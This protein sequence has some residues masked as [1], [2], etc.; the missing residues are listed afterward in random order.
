MV[1]VPCTVPYASPEVLHGGTPGAADDVWA[2]GVVL[3]EMVAG[4]H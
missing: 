1:S 2:L 3:F 4:R